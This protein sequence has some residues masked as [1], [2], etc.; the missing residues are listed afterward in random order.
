MESSRSLNNAQQT[1]FH[2][3]IH[4]EIWAAFQLKWMY[5]PPNKRSHCWY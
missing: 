5:M 2:N 3:S 1:V 4:S